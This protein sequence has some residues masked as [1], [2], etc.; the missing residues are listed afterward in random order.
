MKRLL[1]DTHVL[2]WWLGDEIAL[3]AKAK[4]AIANPA[5]DVFVSAAST[6]EI[7]IKQA[8]GKLSA[9]EDLDAIIEQ[10]QF[11]PLPITLAHGEAAGLLPPLHR[12]PFDRMLIAQAQMEGLL[13][14]TADECISR[15]AV[16][17]MDAGS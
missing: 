12:D 9:P 2:L 5:N 13:L 16:R 14:V 4:S 17:V 11:S 15:Y 3:G 8:L 1:L 10:E 7:S 6:W